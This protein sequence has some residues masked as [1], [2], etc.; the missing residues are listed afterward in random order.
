MV[1]DYLPL[2]G[3]TIHGDV[4]IFD[5]TNTYGV[6]ITQGETTSGLTVRADSDTTVYGLGT[7]ENYSATLTLPQ[8]SGTLALTSQIPTKVSDLTNDSG[9]LT[10][11]QDISGK[12][13]VT[14]TV[15]TVTYDT[16]NKKL[17][18]TINGTTTDIVTAST[19]V[20]DGGGLT[21][22]QDISG[23]ANLSGATFTG[24]VTGT[25]SGNTAQFRNITI[26]TSDPSGGNDGDV[27]IKISS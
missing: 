20:T 12:A 21:S 23:K 10:S 1:G 14:A 2:T 13:N 19:I 5:S 27:W 11:H 4:S 16:T 6:E 15:S 22:H 25:S 3:G 17:Q 7:I 26:S 8:T 9:F 24:A 18:K